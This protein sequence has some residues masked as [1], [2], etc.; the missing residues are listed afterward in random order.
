M[1]EFCLSFFFFLIW[2]P[3]SCHPTVVTTMKSDLYQPLMCV[4]QSIGLCLSCVF[5]FVCVISN[6]STSKK[7][8]IHIKP[9]VNLM[10]YCIKHTRQRNKPKKQGSKKSRVGRVQGVNKF[11]KKDISSIG[12]FFMKQGVS[13]PLPTLT[14]IL[15]SISN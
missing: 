3:E 11:L 14:N 4:C 7:N 6:Q 8:V 15:L 13:N 5:L 1:R 12:G 2:V 9:S 10:P